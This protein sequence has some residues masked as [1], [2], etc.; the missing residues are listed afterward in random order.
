MRISPR[1][2]FYELSEALAE[3]LDEDASS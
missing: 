1:A 3:L 2:V